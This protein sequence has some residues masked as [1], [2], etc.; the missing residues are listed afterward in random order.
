[1][2]KVDGFSFNNG[3]EIVEFNFENGGAEGNVDQFE[4]AIY[5]ENA[6]ETKRILKKFPNQDRDRATEMNTEVG[7]NEEVGPE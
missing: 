5:E 7:R 6:A 4:D 2:Q 3:K 1:M